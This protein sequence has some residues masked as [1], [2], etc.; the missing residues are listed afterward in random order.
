MKYEKNEYYI[1]LFSILF[2]VIVTIVL[3]PKNEYFFGNFVSYWAP[4]VI[5]IAL[6][7]VLRFRPAIIS[8]CAIVLSVYLVC[9]WAWMQSL[10]AR[11]GL[12]WLGYY[13]SLPGAIIGSIIAGIDSKYHLNNQIFKTILISAFLTFIGLFLNQIIVCGTVMYCYLK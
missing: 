11:E 3:S 9:Y 13:F 7:M 12:E 10:P 5:I 1:A 2:G 4:Q 6:L 8:G